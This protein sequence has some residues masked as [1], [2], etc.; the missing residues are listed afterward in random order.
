MTNIQAD[1]TKFRA[2]TG[3]EPQIPFEQTMTD[4]LDWWR[5]RLEPRRV[6]TGLECGW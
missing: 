1:S 5:W 6:V 4:L 3:W 2:L